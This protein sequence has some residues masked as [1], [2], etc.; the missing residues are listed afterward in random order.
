MAYPFKAYYQLFLHDKDGKLI[1]KSRKRISKSFVRQWLQIIMAQLKQS[2][3]TGAIDTGGVSRNIFNY[4]NALGA[5]APY[6]YA[7]YGIVVGTGTGAEANDNYAL[8]AQIAHGTGAGQLQYGS[9]AFTD[10]AIVAGNVDAILTRAFTNVSG[11]TI[12]VN[13]I[14]LYAQGYDGSVRY[15][16]AIRDV[17]SAGVN[18]LN[19]QTLTV[20][21][22][23]RT[24]V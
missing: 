10:P 9:Q 5:N 17:L 4:G 8:G 21:Y 13:E 3:V 23:L 24:T 20:Q 19:G 12:T 7:T 18:V 11:A 15:F 22:T 16:C 1:W 14:G 2:T 6:A